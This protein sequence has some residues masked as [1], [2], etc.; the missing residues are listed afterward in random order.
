MES[1]GGGRLG[2]KGFFQP[3]LAPERERSLQEPDQILAWLEELER[4]EA[5]VE[6][7]FDPADLMPVP[8]EVVRVDEEAGS[9][10]LA[11]RWWCCSASP[12]CA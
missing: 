5:G 4:T 6:L 10:T 9:F 8:G 7:Q 11:P 3:K 2:I 12:R 1:R